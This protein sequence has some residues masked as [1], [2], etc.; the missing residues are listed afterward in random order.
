M[1]A[2]TLKTKPVTCSSAGSTAR[3]S[4]GCGLDRARL[5]RLRSRRRREAGDAVQ[6]LVHAEAPQR[7][8]EVD[9]AQMA[10]AVGREF[11]GRT[12]PAHQLDLLAQARELRL[13]QQLCQ[14]LVLDPAAGDRR[15]RL[16]AG[17]RERQEALARQVVAALELPAHAGR[18]GHGHGIERQQLADLVEQLEGVAPL[19]VELVDE[20]DDRHVAQAADLEQLAGLGLDAL[21][22]VDHHDRGID[23]RQGAVGV[24]AEV[25]VARR[26]EQ[27]EGAAAEIEGH[28]R[29]G[30]G[31]AAGLLDLHPVRARAPA[32]AA[33]LDRAGQVDR[34]AEQ[35]QLLGQGG[36][37]RVRVRDN[38]EGAAPLGGLGY[39]ARHR[40]RQRFGKHGAQGT[41]PV[42]CGKS[43]C[44]GNPMGVAP[45]PLSN[46]LAGSP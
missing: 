37:A 20:G 9:R 10:L 40:A 30:H 1:L 45:G 29:G 44:P 2:C 24:F 11:E 46:D 18:P 35:Q 26:V 33:R 4:A 16:L 6:Q 27:V 21:G 41:P 39:R 25:L 34:P 23:R 22:R 8:A 5:G 3:G 19:A 36:L 15:R 31:D 42:S 38:G 13:G 14:P 28:D 17:P 32:L 12:G 43:C 7:R